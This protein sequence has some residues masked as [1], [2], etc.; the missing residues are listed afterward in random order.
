[1]T[2]EH[3]LTLEPV[4]IADRRS[5]LRV[6]PSFS[7]LADPEELSFRD[8]IE[9]YPEPVVDVPAWI[10]RKELQEKLTYA[11]ARA[12][13]QPAGKI[14]DLGAGSCWLSSM[15][16]LR[17]EVTKVIGVEFSRRRLTELA[18]VAMAYLDAPPEKIERVIADFYNPGLPGESADMVFTDAAYHHA[19]DPDR[20]ARVAYTLLKPGGRFVLFREPTLSLLRRS[21][22]HC[23]ADDHG[24]FEHEYFAREYT[25]QLRDA[26]FRATKHVAS[27]GFRTPRAR[28]MLR[29]PL[30]WLNGIVFSEYTYVGRKPV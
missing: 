11:L 18:P 14:I 10:C 8:Q 7:E 13:V 30:S 23:G 19:A 21:R 4:A 1:M 26:G 22:D 9:D 27:G 17:P 29:P 24:S 12:Q 5:P 15:L 2:G 20:L 3:A 28:A 6:G 16:A 25:R